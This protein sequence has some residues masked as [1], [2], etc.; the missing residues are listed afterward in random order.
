MVTTLNDT[1]L[2]G[3]KSERSSFTSVFMKLLIVTVN[4]LVN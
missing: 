2:G 3:Q 1:F 4:V